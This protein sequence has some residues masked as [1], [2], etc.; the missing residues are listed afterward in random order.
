MT[1]IEQMELIEENKDLRKINELLNKHCKTTDKLLCEAVTKLK[2]FAPKTDEPVCGRDEKI[3]FRC[4][5]W[6]KRK[7][8][9]S[10]LNEA[11][12]EEK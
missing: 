4:A 10:K 9:L 6:V 7:L 12:K 3:H 8:T 2:M 1:P 11:V 5:S